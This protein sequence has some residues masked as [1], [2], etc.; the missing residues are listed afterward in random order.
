M[1]VPH[2][3]DLDI[4]P[5]D[6]HFL[7]KEAWDFDAVP[8]DSYPLLLHFH[9]LV[10]YRHQVLK[11]ADVVLADFL[12]AEEVPPDLRRRNFEFYDPITTGDSSLSPSIQ[13]IAAGEIGDMG[14]AKAHFSDALMV[15]LADLA[16]NTAD[17]VHMASAGGIWLAITAG[18]GGFSIR[19]GHIVLTP[20]LP[21]GWNRLKF[22]TRFRGIL[23]EVDVRPRRLDLVALGGDL[24]LEVFGRQLV[25][26][27]TV[28]VTIER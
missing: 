15:D 14:K 19:R 2:D 16:G 17:G 28:P 12:L 27:D 20:R 26:T 22:R 6:A 9:P 24:T 21:E 11:Q 13:S 3:P 10:I 18:F 7:T 23:L 8:P 25:L 4:T 5:Q 1:F